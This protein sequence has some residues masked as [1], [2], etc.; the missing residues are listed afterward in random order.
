MY[1]EWVLGSNIKWM[2]TPYQ[3]KFSFI[4]R[5]QRSKDTPKLSCLTYLHLNSF[6]DLKGK[7][8]YKLSQLIDQ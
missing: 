4:T 5:L 7:S 2:F 6:I 1:G 8:R 3:Y